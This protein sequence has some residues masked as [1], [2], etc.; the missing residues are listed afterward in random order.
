MAKKQETDKT[1]PTRAKKIVRQGRRPLMTDWH[2]PFLQV[3]R[4]TGMV[5]RACQ[6]VNVGRVTAYRHRDNDPEFAERWDEVLEEAVDE[7]EREAYRRA[8][9]GCPKLKFTKNGEPIYDPATNEPYI[10]REYSD[11]L[12]ITLLKA[13]R[14]EQ[15]NRPT[16]QTNV[17]VGVQVNLTTSQLRE[18]MAESPAGQRMLERL[19]G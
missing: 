4:E 7:M 18:K 19:A 1:P 12:L 3:L 10:E 16:Q 13:R 2:D 5:S 14:P 15:F 6:C 9:L 8:V 17:N 11:T